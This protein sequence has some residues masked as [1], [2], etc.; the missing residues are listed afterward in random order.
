MSVIS[1]ISQRLAGLLLAACA[2][3]AVAASTTLPVPNAGQTALRI[4]GSNTL[5]A[6][7]VP[8]LVQGLMQQQ[9]LQS[10]KVEELSQGSRITGLT[11]ANQPVPVEVISEGSGSGF[12]ALS[13]S[14]AQL[15]ASSRPIK[16]SEMQLLANAGDMQ[17]AQA[18]K[19]VALDGVA[20]I[21]HP[22]NP[23][24]QLSTEQLAAAFAGEVKTWE[25]L[26]ASGGP[27]KIMALDQL[28][29]TFD[30]FN[31]G[32]LSPLGKQVS[33]NAQR[34]SSHVTLAENVVREPGAIG[35]VG[36]PFVGASK[37]VAIADGNADALKPQNELVATEDYPLSRR[38]YFYVQ[39]GESNAWAKALIEFAQ[40]PAGQQLVAANGFVSQEVRTLQV[41]V[42]TQ[43][44][45]S[46]KQL[47]SQAKRL[48]VTFRFKEGQAKLDSKAQQD[49][50]RIAD[51]I[52]ANGKANK[53][54]ALVGFSDA[55]EDAA[56]AELVSKLR[57]M[58]V[59]RE[60]GKA[61]IM[62]RDVQGLGQAMPVA[63]NDVESG[64]IRNRRVEVW[65][66]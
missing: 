42:E 30:T 35:F 40:S 52:K 55:K 27:I 17:S 41:P 13:Q 43:M 16:D 3:P 24:A 28:S 12:T 20:V 39:P 36:L 23:I 57:A 58:A 6:R 26:G 53:A 9:G 49:V 18:E 10:I 63:S 59:R 62:P 34:F 48:T 64:R 19:V 31:S 46:Y 45:E 37:A 66:Y 15:A 1:G 8:A 56:R 11:A 29:G 22:N 32:V 50:Q 7:L 21:V 38:L 4:E 65:V 33:A 2:L 60:L 44:P 25:E 51:F 14:R 5:G 47:A 61:G 54:V